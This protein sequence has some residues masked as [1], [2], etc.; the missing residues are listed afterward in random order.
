MGCYREREADTE[1]LRRKKVAGWIERRL[2]LYV[3]IVPLD[4]KNL[5]G[6]HYQKRKSPRQR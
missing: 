2:P 6:H 5:I 4:E 3:V 1:D